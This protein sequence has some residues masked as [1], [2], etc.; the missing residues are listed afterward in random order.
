MAHD[1]LIIPVT[2][3]ASKAT[4]SAGSRVIDTYHASLSVETV[5]VLYGGDWCRYLHVIKKKN[6]VSKF[7]CSLLSLYK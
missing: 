5:Q 6:K 2:S 3:V 7:F 1:I 4:F